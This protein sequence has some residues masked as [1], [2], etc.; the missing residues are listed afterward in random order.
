MTVAG[1]PGSQSMSL[2]LASKVPFLCKVRALSGRGHD[3]GQPG[4]S[5]DVILLRHKMLKKKLKLHLL[6][7][8]IAFKDGF[9]YCPGFISR[10]ALNSDPLYLLSVETGGICHHSCTV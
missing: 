1:P 10:L 5:E 3:I 7:Q 4:V 2:F 8:N 9:L 6:L